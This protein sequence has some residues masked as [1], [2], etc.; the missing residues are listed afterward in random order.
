M[1]VRVLERYKSAFCYTYI[2][3][4][5]IRIE[6]KDE[7]KPFSEDTIMWIINLLPSFLLFSALSASPCL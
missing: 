1:E 4:R 5:D 3:L 7:Y 6:E 2:P